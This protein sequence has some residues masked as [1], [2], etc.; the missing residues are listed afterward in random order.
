VSL[1]V[2]RNGFPESG[3]LSSDYLEHI[4]AWEAV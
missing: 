3:S 1:C 4:G 2:Y